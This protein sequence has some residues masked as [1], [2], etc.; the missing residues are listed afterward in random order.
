MLRLPFVSSVSDTWLKQM[1]RSA[2][3]QEVLLRVLKEGHG[4]LSASVFGRQI[5]C[6]TTEILTQSN[7]RFKSSS[8]SESEHWKPVQAQWAIEAANDR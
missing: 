3:S 7:M 1:R 6:R 5:I 2:K 8:E 4:M